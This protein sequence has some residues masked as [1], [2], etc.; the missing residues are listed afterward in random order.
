MPRG[1]KSKLKIEVRFVGIRIGWE[2]RLLSGSQVIVTSAPVESLK[3][4]D[5]AARRFKSMLTIEVPIRIR[6]RNPRPCN[7]F[8]ASRGEAPH[9][10]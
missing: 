5:R 7:R 4:A 2:F 10:C 1:P 9:R 8:L 3:S 6:G